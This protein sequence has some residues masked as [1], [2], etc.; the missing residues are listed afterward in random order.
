MKSHQADILHQFYSLKL[1]YLELFECRVHHPITVKF[2]TAQPDLF[3]VYILDGRFTFYTADGKEIVDTAKGQ[4]YADYTPA[5]TYSVTLAPG[6]HAILY[7]V[8]SPE[9]LDKTRFFPGLASING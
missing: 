8:I 3:L 2:S 7:I 1:A 9:W 5:G 6:N 4:Y